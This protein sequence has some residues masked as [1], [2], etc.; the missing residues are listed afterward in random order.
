MKIPLKFVPK[1][2]IDNKS[3][4]MRVM[5]WHRTADKPQP[6][7]GVTKALFVDLSVSK[8][9]DLAKTLLRCFD[10]HS[11]LTGVAAAEL[12]RYLPKIKVMFNR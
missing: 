8:I 2:Q 9:F 7:V 3:S 12:Q 10:S 11:Y 4:L 1:G 5:D 6:G